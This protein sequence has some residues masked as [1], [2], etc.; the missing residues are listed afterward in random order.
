MFIAIIYCCKIKNYIFP[1]LMCTYLIVDFKKSLI[2]A[3]KNTIGKH[4]NISEY[5]YHFCHELTG[6]KGNYRS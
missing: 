2:N 1:D 5:F 3:S 4:I 6:N